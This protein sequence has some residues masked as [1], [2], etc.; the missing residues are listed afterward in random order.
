MTFAS[1]VP[2]VGGCRQEGSALLLVLFVCLGVV[3][4]IQTLSTVVLCAERAVIDESVGRYHASEKDEGLAIVRSQVLASWGPLS[5]TAITNAPNEVQAQVSDLD[6]GLGWVMRVDVRQAPDLSPT[7]TSAWLER[8]RDGIDLPLVALV[9]KRVALAPDR[10]SAW[11]EVDASALGGAPAV[12]DSVITA[13]ACL[14]ERPAGLASTCSYRVRELSEEWRLDDGWRLLGRSCT[15]PGPD[16]IWMSSSPGDTVGLPEESGGRSADA[17]VLV[18]LIG[19]GDLDLRA[20]GDLHGVVVVDGGSVLL[21]GTVLHGAAF[22]SET[23]TLG[24]R[25]SIRYCPPLL[26]WATDRSLCRARLVPG[27]RWEGTG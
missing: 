25:G 16:V 10:V 24:A 19:G 11:L 22:V 26:R 4:A 2:G 9:A 18:V 14:V 1:G 27:S 7:V 13:T 15:A 21:E 5:W 8:G 12:P 20:R 3:V 23:V 6:G 17:P